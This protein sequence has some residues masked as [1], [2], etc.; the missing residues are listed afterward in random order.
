MTAPVVWSLLSG[1]FD[2]ALLL[3]VV[4]G[5]SDG[6]DGFLAKQFHWQSWLGAILDP[7]ADKLL[8]VSCF[9]ALGWLGLLPAWLV[10]AVIVRDLVI[11]GGAV[12]W[13]FQIKTLDAEPTIVSKINTFMQIVL[14]VSVVAEQTFVW[15]PQGGVGALIWITLATTASSGIDYVWEWSKRARETVRGV[16]KEE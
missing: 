2:L 3:F 14:V 10:V 7:L 13:H 9:F 5:I 4:A 15:L 1:R 12:Y 6:V 16:F 8:L 11:V